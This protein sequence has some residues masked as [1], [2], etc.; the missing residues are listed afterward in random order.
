MS[1]ELTINNHGMNQSRFDS[2]VNDLS[3]N[4]VDGQFLFSKSW[5]QP[6]SPHFVQQSH[7]TECVFKQ[8]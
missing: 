5:G 8:V 3:K 2:D 6:L 7:G 4:F 1:C